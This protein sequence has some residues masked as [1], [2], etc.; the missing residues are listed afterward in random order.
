MMMLKAT[1]EPMTT[2]DRR[3]VKT[4]VTQSALIGMLRSGLTFLVSALCSKTYLL[5]SFLQQ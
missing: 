2:K 5:G 3:K 4:R 1:E